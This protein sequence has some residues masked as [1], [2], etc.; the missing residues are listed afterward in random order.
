MRT[1]ERINQALKRKVLS[2]LC[3]MRDYRTK[4]HII[5]IESDDWGSVR[6]PQRP[7]WEKLKN[8]GFAVD[9]RPYE[10]LDTLESA[11]DLN[12]L[13]NV[14][15][16]YK[17]FKGNHPIITANMLMAN[18]DFS[19]IEKSGYMEYSYEPISS[20]YKRYFGN[21]KALHLM[22]EGYDEGVFMPQSHGREH[23][24]FRKWLKGLQQGD[25][26]LLLAFQYGV[27]GIAPRNN[28]NMGNKIMN[29]FSIENKEEQEELNNIVAEGLEL[30][31]QFWGFKSKTFVAPCY[32]WN[33]QTERVLA[34]GGVQ[35][36][37]TSRCCKSDVMIPLRYFY[38]G[39][40][41]KL[42]IRYS[43]RNLQFEPAT[44]K[45]ST[46]VDALMQQVEN[47][48]AANK[49]AIFSSHRI[50]YVSGIEP[51][52]LKQTLNLLDEFL[53]RLLQ[54]YPDIEFMS[55]DQL[56]EVFEQK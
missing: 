45:N 2:P 8:L 13:F 5:V 30:F 25:E 41:N 27:C 4:R 15:S 24:N 10:R 55:S 48:F 21:D 23:F 51:N 44:N 17:D 37:Q 11:E 14:L 18:P 38:S 19:E 49:I 12:N 43:I 3:E 35:L 50:N 31:E 20:T 47:C 26:D 33:K 16:K 56:I 52:N 46:N 32:L 40:R 53:N 39:Q 1:I 34:K 9:K 29:A 42:G 28:P 36:I 22:K 7:E 6:M 54:Q